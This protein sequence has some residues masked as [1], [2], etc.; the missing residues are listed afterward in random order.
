MLVAFNC[1][2]VNKTQHCSTNVAIALSDVTIHTAKR[3]KRIIASSA[4]QLGGLLITF[5]N[6]QKRGLGVDCKD[7]ARS[8]TQ[9]AIGINCAINL[10]VAWWPDAN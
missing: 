7:I 8:M 1:S 3:C 2:A 9:S 6:Q 10:P 4:V 5:H